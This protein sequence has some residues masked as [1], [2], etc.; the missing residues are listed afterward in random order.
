MRL[1][2]V[3][4]VVIAVSALLWGSWQWGRRPFLLIASLVLAGLIVLAVGVWQGGKDDQVYLPPKGVE[5]AL[6]E[7]RDS[8]SGVRLS[9]TVRNEGTQDVAA[10]SLQAQALHCQSAEDCQVIYQQPITL[11]MYLPRGSEY[12]FAVVS[13][14]PEE[15][16]RVDR[17]QLRV[18]EKL[19]YPE[20]K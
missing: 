7:I 12:Q 16:T 14:H 17:W 6:S 10:L 8:E 2:L 15:K 11:Q 3:L 5:L 19:A 1:L 4:T 9:G 13:R 20:Q 18:V